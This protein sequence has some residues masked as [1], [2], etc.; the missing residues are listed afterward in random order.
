VKPIIK[1]PF[2]VTGYIAPEYFCDRE[3]ETADLVANILNGRNT[4]LISER[5][6]GKT[7]LIEHVYHQSQIADNYY[8]FLIDI[9]SVGSLREFVLLLGKHIFE[10][11]KPRGQKFVDKFFSTI[12]SLRP[13]FKLDSVTGTPT[14]DIGMG[15][16]R[17]PEVSLEQIFRYLEKANKRCVVAIDE[18][19]QVAKFPEKSVEA[20]LRTHIQ[21]CK[22]TNFIFAGSM[23]HMMSEIFLSA[24]R[25]FYQSVAM[26][27]LNSIE[28]KKYSAFASAFFKK[29]GV[30]IPEKTIEF[31]YRITAGTTGYMQR[32]MN[33]IYAQS[34]NGDEIDASATISALNNVVKSF[35]PLYQQWMADL[36]ERQKEVLFAIAKETSVSEIT[37]SDF[38]HRH[39]LKS[40]SSVQSSVKQ[41]IAKEIVVKS[42]GKYYIQDYFFFFWLI[43]FYGPGFHEIWFPVIEWQ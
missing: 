11:L 6:M 16:I 35:E 37:S 20:L 39:A 14:F 4:A 28:G 27:T 22:N 1:N 40:A 5:R 18:F 19:Q 15:E 33:E 32:I 26:I 41:L 38:I 13:A 24:S 31:V 25:P 2:V 43:M 42:R 17:Q 10:T 3:K 23:Q 36:T 21:H 9:Y 30:T 7:G 34:S 8:T 12:T 29:A